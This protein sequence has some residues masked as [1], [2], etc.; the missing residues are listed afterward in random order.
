MIEIP[1]FSLLLWAQA[2]LKGK[3]H[4]WRDHLPLLVSNIILLLFF[5]SAK[6]IF[7]DVGGSKKKK[8]RSGRVT[9]REKE[10][11]ASPL[12]IPIDPDEPT[13]CLC[14]QV[15]PLNSHFSAAIALILSC[16]YITCLLP[17][18]SCALNSRAISLFCLLFKWGIHARD[19]KKNV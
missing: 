5:S 18:L 15:S 3:W 6:I 8:R 11:S 19:F 16:T 12:E 4:M 10:R 13:Y 7:I 17:S 9:E 2:L 1:L 14:D